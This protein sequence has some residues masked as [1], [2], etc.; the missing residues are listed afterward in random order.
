MLLLDCDDWM[1][2]KHS[3]SKKDVNDLLNL[4]KNDEILRQQMAEILRMEL[5]GSSKS[6]R[7]NNH[8]VREVGRLRR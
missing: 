7:Q 5:L 2:P 1:K 8:Y 6:A 4:M 3:I